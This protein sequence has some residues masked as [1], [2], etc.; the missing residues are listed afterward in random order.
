MDRSGDRTPWLIEGGKGT[1]PMA[2]H[3]QLRPDPLAKEQVRNAAEYL[4]IAQAGERSEP[5]RGHLDGHGMASTNL[6]YRD[7]HEQRALR[8][9]TLR[10]RLFDVPPETRLSPSAYGAGTTERVY[11][12]LHDQAL[13]ALSAGYSAI[14]DATFLRAE[15][16]K[17]IAQSAEHT[18]VPFIGLW[19]EAPREVLAA[20]IGARRRDA[21]DADLLVLEQQL[22]ID[23]GP[24]DWHRIDSALDIATNV[25]ALR[26]LIEPH[27]YCDRS[28]PA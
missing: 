19:L 5:G 25:A 26:A 27:M 3:F 24:M 18:R 11:R 2:A 22:K 13:A 7:R 10:K 17:R 21:S 23:I 20:R 16:R 4:P 9:D 6:R 28:I 15:E 1:K 12:G 8:Q 14:V